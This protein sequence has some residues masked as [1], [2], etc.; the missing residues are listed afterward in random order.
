M[1]NVSAVRPPV[2]VLMGVSGCGKS[3]V[4]GLHAGPVERDGADGAG[5]HA[6]ANVESLVAGDSLDGED[7]WP[8]LATVGEWIGEHRDAG[9]SGVITRSALTKSDR[10]SV[11][12]ERAVFVYL[13]G[14]G[15]QIAHL[16]AG[17]HGDCVP[18]SLVDSRFDAVQPATPEQDSI[19]IVVAV[20]SSIESEKTDSGPGLLPKA[21]TEL[22]SSR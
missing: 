16:L 17:R 19:L 3:A 6:A 22:R 8:R 9:R 7:R 20:N 13:A 4:A 2:L 11:D 5:L 21:A 18:A 10:G 14:V 1:I 15:V 12:G